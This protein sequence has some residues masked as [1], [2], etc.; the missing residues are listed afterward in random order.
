MEDAVVVP[1]KG[2]RC[3]LPTVSKRTPVEDVFPRSAIRVERLNV[4]LREILEHQERG[5][6]VPVLSTSDGMKFGFLLDSG[7]HWM[8][9]GIFHLIDECG[10][11]VD[12]DVAIQFRCTQMEMTDKLMTPEGREWI[13]KGV[14]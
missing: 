10:P 2:G 8:T 12:L 13:A 4:L 14:K 6:E 11:E 5:I 7:W 9:R 3:L 1:L